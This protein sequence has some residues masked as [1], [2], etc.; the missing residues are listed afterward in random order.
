[1]V[2]EASVY[3]WLRKSIRAARAFKGFLDFPLDFRRSIGT[4]FFITSKSLCLW[5]SF[6]SNPMDWDS[7]LSGKHDILH[8]GLTPF[9]PKDVDWENAEDLL[10]KNIWNDSSSGCGILTW[11]WFKYVWLLLLFS[12]IETELPVLLLPK[13]LSVFSGFGFGFDSLSSSF[14]ELRTVRIWSRFDVAGGGV[15]GGGAPG[16]GTDMYFSYGYDIISEGQSQAVFFLIF[17]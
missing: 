1:M 17:G 15:D 16:S 14:E 3:H 10:P 5:H 11:L 4:F 7:M 13:D 2:P 8:T 9:D 6:I 12:A